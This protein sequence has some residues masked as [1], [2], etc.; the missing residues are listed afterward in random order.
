[1]GWV[2]PVCY[3]SN[4]KSWEGLQRI[5]LVLAE[6]NVLVWNGNEGTPLHP[7]ESNVQLVFRPAKVFVVKGMCLHLV[8]I[9]LRLQVK[10]QKCIQQVIY[11]YLWTPSIVFHYHDILTY[12]ER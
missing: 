6:D 5:E 8:W 1:M 2:V 3:V 7:K 4:F 9:T 11:M 10:F 12:S